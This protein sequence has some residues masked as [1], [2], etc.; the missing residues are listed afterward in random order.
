MLIG[1]GGAKT[2][3]E[4]YL[5]PLYLYQDSA[6]EIGKLDKIPNFTAEFSKFKVK[7][8]VLKDKSVEQILAFI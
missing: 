4:T 8:K 6:K 7:S 2:G 3:S 1:R 5:T